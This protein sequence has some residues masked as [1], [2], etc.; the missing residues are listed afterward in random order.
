MPQLCGTVVLVR[1]IIPGRL[2]AGR[3]SLEASIVVRIHA[4]ERNAMP[5]GVTGN[6]TDSDS[7]VLG[8][9]PGEAARPP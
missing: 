4:G 3:C 8:S 1:E 9:N 5:R 7:V 6:T 2:K